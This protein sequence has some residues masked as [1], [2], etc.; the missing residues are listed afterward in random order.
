MKL[1]CFY[2]LNVCDD[3]VLL[4]IQ[5]LCILSTLGLIIITTFRRLD[6]VLC[7][8]QSIEL[9][10]ISGPILYPLDFTVLCLQNKV[11]IYYRKAWSTFVVGNSTECTAS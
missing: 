10:M 4:E 7:W 1:T 11:Y 5:T 8:A 2:V 3:G 9:V 6:Q